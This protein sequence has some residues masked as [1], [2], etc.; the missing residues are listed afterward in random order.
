MAGDT[1]PLART[2]RER[3][4]PGAARQEAQPARGWGGHAP[5]PSLFLQRRGST[6]NLGFRPAQCATFPVLIQPQVLSRPGRVNLGA[7]PWG[8]I[9]SRSA[10]S[11]SFFPPQGPQRKAL[12]TPDTANVTKLENRPRFPVW[13]GW[14][15]PKPPTSLSPALRTRAWCPKGLPKGQEGRG[16]D[17]LF[18][19]CMSR[20]LP[21]VTL[22]AF[23]DTRFGLH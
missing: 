16:W 3:P 13:G 9:A 4:G 15:A 5:C 17:I 11:S 19:D 20:L 21:A 8:S 1:P 18:A 23:Q 7:S 6:P 2:V 12:S 10:M 22:P 14:A